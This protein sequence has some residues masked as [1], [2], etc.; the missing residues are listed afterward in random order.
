[1][2][3]NFFNAC[4]FLLFNGI[5]CA[6][7]TPNGSTYPSGIATV[8]SPGNFVSGVKVNSIRTI[9]PKVAVFEET[10][11]H[12]TASDESKIITEY[13]DGLGRIIETVSHYASPTGKDVVTLVKYDNFGRGAWH[14]LPYAKAES[15][16]D[17]NGKFK[18]SPFTDQKNFYKVDMGY[19]ADN[20]FYSQNNYEP[21][22][23]NRLI[24]DLPQ[25]NSWVGRNRGKTITENPL[26]AGA[27]IRIFTMAFTTGSLP[28]TTTVFNTGELSVKTIIDEDNNFTEEY[29]N[30]KGEL[31]LKATGK[32][33]NMVKLQ[34][35][36]VYD[37]LGLLK[38][39]IPPKAVAWLAANSWI[40]T[41]AI[42][43]ELCFSYVYDGRLRMIS[44][45]IPGAGTQYLVY[46]TKDEVIFTQTPTQAVK[47]EY[48]FNKYDVLG[49][50]IQAG[51]YYSTATASNLQNLA[52]TSSPGTDSFLAYL[53]KDIY[54]N[55]SYSTAFSNAK[56]L[57]TNYYDD[58]SFTTRAYNSSFMNSLPTGWNS[59]V[60]QET[61]NLLTGTKMVVLDG[62]ATPTEL[63][64]V[65]F[66]NDRGLLIQT[67]AQNHKGG[68][69]IITNSYDFVRQK[70][71]TYT[72]LNNPAAADNAKI[73]TVETFFYDHAGRLTGAGHNLN[74][75][76]LQ[77]SPSNYNFDE[78][79]R[80]ANKN[81]SNGML[82]SIEFEYNI[83]DWLTG[84]NKNYCLNNTTDKTFGM[85]LS[86][87]YGY[88]TNYF[89]GTI[90]GMK[91][92]NSGNASQLRSYGYTYDAYNRLK[93]GDFVMKPGAITSSFPFS[94][95]TA[96]FTVSNMVYDEN[97]N[98]Q[99]M[100]Q[101]GR[102]LAGQTIV[103]DD[104]TYGYAPNSNKLKSVTESANSQSKNP[105]TYDNLGDFRDVAGAYDY[106]HDENGNVLTDANKSLSFVYDE[107]TNKTRR[108]TKGNQSVDYLYDAFGSKLQKKVT[109]TSGGATSV[110][111]YI[112]GAV[113]INNSLSFINHSEGRIRYIPTSANKYQYDYF[114]KDHLGSTRSIVTYT[115]G[116][117]T[118]LAKTTS[119][120]SNE[121]KYIAT[122]EPENAAKE[123]QLFDNV[124]I[125][126]SAKPI[127]KTVMDNYVAKISAK[128]SK[129]I[130]GP[131]ITLKVMAGDTVKISAEALYIPE[132]ANT[133]AIA[134]D[135]I[136]NF[137]SAF[138][139]LPSLAAEGIS[140]TTSN[141]KDL[142][143]AILNMQ[144]QST[145]S[146]APKAFLNYVL[147]DQYMNLVPEGSGAIQVKNKDGWQTL[148][149]DQIAISQNGFLRVFSNNME[150]A[151]VSI[152]NTTVAA[153]PGKLVEEYNYY[154]YGL[155]F[156][157][158]LQS[159][160]TIPKTN[161]LYSGKELQHSE[162]GDGNG[163]ELADYGARMYDPQIGRWTGVDPK[164]EKYNSL[165]PYSY[166]NNNP[167]NTID[168]DGRDIII[169]NAEHSVSGLGH[170]AIL[171][172]T[173][174]GG[175]YLYSKNGT[176][177]MSGA[178]GQ[179]ESPDR[180]VYFKTL[181]D[182]AK[183]NGNFDLEEHGEVVFTR[184]FRIP[185]SAKADEKMA[186]AALESVDS[187]YDVTGKNCVDVPSDA[188]EAIGL[189]GGAELDPAKEAI[190]KSPIPN[191]RYE[192][193]KRQ[194]KT[195]VD[196]TESITPS[197][198]T[199]KEMRENSVIGQ[200]I[201]EEG[202]RNIAE[203]NLPTNTA[204]EFSYP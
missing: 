79:G 171:I 153:I 123:N 138:T 180:G 111:D 124:D 76:N 117:I 63:I 100:K 20:Y 98:L 82:P 37:D 67:Q 134:K 75:L 141:S 18:L 40:L 127:N 105:T 72:E 199:K 94:S 58:Y 163:L 126:R 143:T 48:L 198:E 165:A 4:Y 118:G 195:G 186:D 25:G 176:N 7:N 22:P 77:V 86:Y 78:L 133:N 159:S 125:T 50:L 168:F 59:T 112:G 90:A 32:M 88:T 136:N 27:N 202:E 44:K 107:L 146:D 80:L 91:W 188:L 162:F 5:L 10:N 29:T 152:N 144:K 65:N 23:L 71:G 132:N 179:S 83:R 150:A 122:S 115:N 161:Y 185:T 155:V 28:L 49:R 16:I 9:T 45:N 103:L 121:V 95:T 129:T 60:S 167:I 33:G 178:S 52:N 93:A 13:F 108:V 109:S 96:N 174:R 172:G 101:L 200:Q 74:D 140:T 116:A 35:Y 164:T 85:E 193:I 99:R 197:E 203:Q 24:K 39:V 56:V 11:I 130:L 192:A 166:C 190:G 30:K 41:A 64:S 184:A 137:I 187:D 119:P 183:S 204:E 157:Q 17:D 104:L 149:T 57:L 2:N 46:N 169:L 34:T 51:V 142:A 175:W 73:K 147:Y 177:G 53:F 6:Q 36:Y 110:T 54:G 139:T 43:S 69:N 156:G 148:E 135:V 182:F 62:A 173:D 42:S 66:Y 61:T 154:P 70:Q 15:N 194:N 170:A 106:T 81:F 38:F 14:F 31:I 145:T 181:A 1:M 8:L 128:N 201:I 131:D 113:Y 160:T 97:G 84:I 158:T 21:S 92:R 102:N 12:V 191:D 68:W 189:N 87:D 26:A 3:S 196:A 19:A 89:N 47:G 151:P 120:A 55:V 114:V